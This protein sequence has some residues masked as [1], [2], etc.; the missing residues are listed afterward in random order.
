MTLTQDWSDI[1]APELEHDGSEIDG[2][3]F[4]AGMPR[5]DVVR[6]P[7]CHGVSLL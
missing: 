3:E 4:N 5:I 2:N 7:I 1:S 6:L